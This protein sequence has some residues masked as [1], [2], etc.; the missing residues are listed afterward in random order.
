MSLNII[1]D[2]QY[3]INIK[4]I[5]EE[6]KWLINHILFVKNVVV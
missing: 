3:K 5:L 6:L 2:S 1:K 4:R